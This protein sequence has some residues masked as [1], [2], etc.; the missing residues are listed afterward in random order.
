MR[1]R[2]LLP[3]VLL[4]CLAHAMWDT[5]VINLEA[6]YNAVLLRVTPADTR[7][8]EVFAG[9]DLQDVTWWNRDRRDDGSGIAPATETLI[10]YPDESGASMF[11]RV[12]GGHTYIIHAK[13]A[14]ALTVVGVPA[15]ANTKVWFGE[16][17]LTGLNLP[18]DTS[19]IFYADYFEGLVGHMDGSSFSVVGKKDAAATLWPMS[20]TIPNANQ[21]IWFTPT[22][23]GSADYMG[24]LHVT[25]DAADNAI[26]FRESTEVRRIT[27]KNVTK[28]DRVLTISLRDSA[29]PPAGQGAKL[30]KAAFMREEIDWSVGFPRRAYVSSDLAI[31]TNLA[32]GASFEL[33]I[34]PDLDKMP[35]ADD[36]AYMAVL[37]ISD[38]GTTVGG[39]T[40]SG[41]TCRHRIGVSVYAN[42][43]AAKN[44][45][46]LWVGTAAISGV[47]R[48]RQM[49]SADNVWDENRIEPVKE[50]FLFRL[51]VHVDNLG[52]ARLLKEVFVATEADVDSEPT[53]LAN[54]TEAIAWR[55]AHPNA[56]IRRISSA[57][58]PNFGD[59][60]ILE[61]T[62]FAHGGT[63]TT[64]TPLRQEYNDN[65]NPFVHAYHPQHD[66]VKFENKEMKA[67]TT[68]E[69]DAAEQDGTG[70][71]ESW[72]VARR[73]TLEFAESDPGG[74]NYDWNR[75]V[76]GGIYRETVTSLT[77]TPILVEGAFRLNKVV[78][79]HILTGL[80]EK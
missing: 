31:T 21:A 73:I 53:L 59:P 29:T 47:N 2:L 51:L 79:T 27:V 26:V 55:G 19:E 10:W 64:A 48:A 33:A 1:K 61:G 15:K 8:S 78:D 30:G 49:G 37:E 4:P 41:G 39:V 52:V 7:C 63:L 11:S 67:Y 34:R 46:G 60:K 24:P 35:A 18:D 54:R 65:T 43:S 70:S 75:T 66:N 50:P 62:G 42:L 5:Q 40:P 74:A 58:F 23:A 20:R 69:Q 14:C 68:K 22:G 16:P 25:V 9:C 17:N 76:T 28:A 45:A 6:G 80:V 71:Y 32:A 3:L 77:K 13:T 57:N 44:P 12:L 72:P 36:G 56:K 38:A